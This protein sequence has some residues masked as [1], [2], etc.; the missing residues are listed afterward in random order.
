MGDRAQIMSS[1]GGRQGPDSEQIEQSFGG[2]GNSGLPVAPLSPSTASFVAGNFSGTK[3]VDIGGLSAGETVASIS[4]NDG[5]VVANAAGTSLVVGL[6][7]SKPS[8]TPY[9]VTTSAGRTLPIAIKATG[10]NYPV[11]LQAPAPTGSSVVGAS[12]SI[13]GP[14][15][16]DKGTYI[17]AYQW[18]YPDTYP[19]TLLG[20]STTS[21]AAYTPA[22]GDVGHP[23]ACQITATDPAT[24]ATYSQ[25]S[26]LTPI[27][28]ASAQ[29]AAGL[30]TNLNGISFTPY[31]A[32]KTGFG[33]ERG[34]T[35]GGYARAP[36]PADGTNVLPVGQTWTMECVVGGMTTAPTGLKVAGGVPNRGFLGITPDGKLAVCVYGSVGGAANA[37]QYLGG[38]NSTAGGAS[39]PSLI[40]GNRHHIRMVVTPTTAY[41]YMDGALLT[42]TTMV[43]N[44]GAGTTL[45]NLG[46]YMNQS[47]IFP[48]SIDEFAVF[49]SALST[50]STYTVPTAPYVGNEANIA[51]LY[52]LDGNY[53]AAQ[54][55]PIQPTVTSAPTLLRNFMA[56]GA[57]A[58]VVNGVYRN[59]PTIYT[60]RWGY[61]VNGTGSDFV[62]ISGATQ[63]SYTP[64]S[65]DQ[66]K[67]VVVEQTAT[68]SAGSAVSYGPAYVVQPQRN[69]KMVAG[70]RL[71]T[72]TLFSG[73]DSTSVYARAGRQFRT[74]NSTTNATA[75]FIN[76][77]NTQSG[78]F[79]CNS[80]G[81]IRQAIAYPI[82][83]PSAVV[84]GIAYSSGNAVV[85]ANSLTM[86]AQSNPAMG[87][88]TY[89][90]FP[91][92]LPNTDYMLDVCSSTVA[93][94]QR[95]YDYNP[96]P[97]FG[98]ELL[99]NEFNYISS[100][101]LEGITPTF[102]NVGATAYCSTYCVAIVAEGITGPSAVIFADSLD[103]QL[104]K[105]PG[106]PLDS[107]SFL[108]V[109]FS[110]PGSTFIPNSGSIRYSQ[111]IG[112]VLNT[113]LASQGGTAVLNMW[114]A[115][116][117]DLGQADYPFNVAFDEHYRNAAEGAGPGNNACLFM[118]RIHARS[119]G[120]RVVLMTP[121][122]SEEGAAPNP[123][124]DPK[125]YTDEST[126]VPLNAAFGPGS[127]RDAYIAWA[128][129]GGSGKIDVLADMAQFVQGATASWKWPRSSFSTKLTQPTPSTSGTR[130]YTQDRPPDGAVLVLNPGGGSAMSIL[131]YAQ[132]I[133]SNGD[134]TWAIDVRT[135]FTQPLAAGTTVGMSLTQDGTHPARYYGGLLTNYFIANIKPAILNAF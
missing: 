6:T 11:C 32:G 86:P 2:G 55:G 49:M 34:P 75:C 116:A 80:D 7:A 115:I 128:R 100:T 98:G 47:L 113:N 79:S 70:N 31:Q 122:P 114:D 4:P 54:F 39:M 108:R 52:H 14:G 119:P 25:L 56:V 110:D 59:T 105:I 19:V 87:N 124:T 130:L 92:L 45:F 23:L 38:G 61:S 81:I 22:S 125:G 66:G 44:T 62:P 117:D 121:F 64:V 74:G 51:S 82:S 90:T 118:D 94:G 132:N 89:I 21:P 103:D 106:T 73:V 101:P 88:R 99:P 16:W 95:P 42:S 109:G 91:G 127:T 28:V 63:S 85:P 123:T 107:G 41:A 133:A 12:V 9:S 43:P 3:I 120:C 46:S 135:S 131:A 30:G 84:Q 33:Q 60:H 48:G 1:F 20:S 35:T 18:V 24:G 83:N 36:S 129:A 50:G 8:L 57:R 96:V 13:P 69:R 112:N 72:A 134:G 65:A 111:S 10:P 29:S 77:F 15:T 71:R 40:D 17:Y 53:N 67:Q 102:G 26:G 93:G 76:G 126:A 78:L 68:N 104:W 27:V 5:R 58:D 97:A 37:D